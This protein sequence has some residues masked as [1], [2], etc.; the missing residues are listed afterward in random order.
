MQV[1][2]ILE[3]ID[4]G[5]VALPEFQRGY[6]WNR[7]QVRAFMQS[8]YRRYPVGSLLVWVT[9]TESASSR[10][11]GELTPGYVKLLLDGQQRITSLY[12]IIKGKP[13]AFF[14]GN[15]D[16]FTGLYFN[17]DEESFEFYAPVKMKDNPAWI[18]VTQLMKDGPGQFL[19]FFATSEQHREKLP[20][21]INRITSL[22]GIRDVTFHIEEVAGP[23]R[24]VDVVVDIFNRVNSG[25]TKLSKGDLALAKICA[26]WPAAREEMTKRL[27]KWKNAG[28]DFRLDWLLRNVNTVL[29]GEALFSALKD[30]STTDFQVSLGKAERA[31]DSLLNLIG[32]RLGLDHDRVLG[33]RYAFPVMSR[34]VNERGGKL[35]DPRDRDKLLYWY[36]HCFLWGRYAGSTETVM[37]Q[38]LHVLEDNSSGLDG[39]IA[40]LRQARADLRIQPDDFRGWSLGARFYPLIYLLTRVYG[41]RDWCTGV[42]LSQNLLGKY[43]Q[44]HLHHIFPK[45]Y[46]YKHGYQVVD[47]NAIANFA[48]LTLDSNLLISDKPPSEY[49]PKIAESQPGALESQ[50]VPM[51]P[52]LWKPENYLDFLSERRRLLATAANSFLDGLLAGAIPELEPVMAAPSLAAPTVPTTVGGIASSDEE[53]LIFSLVDWA[54]EQGLPEPEV[55]YELVD[56]DS[57]ELLAVI[58]VAWPSGL[59]E[60]LTQPVAVLIEEPEL[61]QK[62]VNEA[63]Y[64][65]FTG[66]EEFKTYALEQTQAMVAV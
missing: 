9:E 12:G 2:N 66:V 52:E 39:L 56:P 30:T 48:F 44:L 37:N 45:S 13:P 35:T 14:E 18:D 7:E 60:G 32:S 25:G 29:T 22:H 33:A 53:E 17:L 26:A 8:L 34:F 1:F 58:D 4:L 59:Q 64:L 15:K 47:V 51:D 61:I 20:Q 55:M 31:I 41:A 49:L 46:L 23:D 65:Y 50:W 28:F 40:Q 54:V 27:T 19:N 36:V 57:N 16:A 21:Y 3:Q 6:V 43:S 11:D 62:A 5:A 24:T 42:A 10:G 63:G 38:D